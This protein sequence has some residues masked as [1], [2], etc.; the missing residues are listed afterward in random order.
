MERDKSN[1][2]FQRLPHGQQW[3]SRPPLPR[4]K[5]RSSCIE[6]FCRMLLLATCRHTFRRV[7][8]ISVKVVGGRDHP[9]SIKESE[10]RASFRRR[11][12]RRIFFPC[13]LPAKD[14]RQTPTVSP[15]RRL[16]IPE[17]GA[18]I[19]G[20]NLIISRTCQTLR[21]PA[22]N[23]NRGFRPAGGRTRSD[24]SLWHGSATDGRAIRS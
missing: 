9:P 12:V 17:I 19:Y 15:G 13:Y 8:N 11:R 5:I 2:R 6:N 14:P 1:A 4:F 22:G 24:L 16:I 18:T 23:P 20:E 10:S 3:N 21:S 7:I